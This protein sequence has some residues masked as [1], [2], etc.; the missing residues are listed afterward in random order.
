[1]NSQS[2]MEIKFAL[3]EDALF[4]DLET[5]SVILSHAAGSYFGL[6]GAAR[7]VLDILHR[8]GTVEEM[9]DRVCARYQVSRENASAD[10][11]R[12][13]H[14]LAQKGLLKPSMRPDSP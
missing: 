4:V 1:M 2:A 9:V 6:R 11:R 14:E 8:G 13:L 3:A 5:E 7:H 12:T 10:I